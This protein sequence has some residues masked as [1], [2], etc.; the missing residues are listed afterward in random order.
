MITE[1]KEKFGSNCMGLKINYQGEFH[2]RPKEKL[3]FCEAVSQAFRFPFLLLPEN[4]ACMGSMRSMGLLNDDSLLIKQIHHE[5][6]I[7]YPVIHYALKN[8]P[9]FHEPLKNV[10]MGMDENLEKEVQPDMFI[11]FLTPARV[12]NLMKEYAL[13]V[14][15]F[16]V[17]KPYIFLSICANVLVSTYQSGIMS[18]SLGCPESRKFSG[19]ADQQMVAGIPYNHG[20]KLLN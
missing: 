11:V 15:Q 5:S 8:I 7:D 1:L 13:K 14:K 4:L 20:L 9:H 3:R 10:L 17:V 2:Q 12:M 19:L 6:K 18:I 16:P